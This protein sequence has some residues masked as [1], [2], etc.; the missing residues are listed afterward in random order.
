MNEVFVS[1]MYLDA[2]KK[3][4]LQKEVFPILSSELKEHCSNFFFE[5]DRF[6]FLAGRKLLINVLEKEGLEPDLINHLKQNEFG[7]PFIENAPDFNI[8][9]SEDLVVLAWCKNREIGVDAEQIRKVD[10]ADYEEFFTPAEKESIR[11]HT[12]PSAECLRIWTRKEALGKCLGKGLS[13]ERL[14]ALDV[15]KPF[16]DVEGKELFFHE[17]HFHPSYIV[18][19][20]TDLRDANF[21]LVEH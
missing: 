8:S 6:H 10:F 16:V 15:R 12:S 14:A 3:E 7:R 2:P 9:H 20:A 4:I 17:L 11:N 1:W 13:D 21:L 18:H 19:L 5:K